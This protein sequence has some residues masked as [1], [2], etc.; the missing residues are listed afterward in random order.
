MILSEQ[1]MLFDDMIKNL[2]AYP[3][4]YQFIYE[5]LIL[6]ERKL[7]SI[8]DP[9]VN[10]AL[11]FCFLKRL[12]DKQLVIHNRIFEVVIS[13]YMITKD[14]REKKREAR[15]RRPQTGRGQRRPL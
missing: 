10:R 7:N 5:L 3:D 9:V 6:G 4:L 13:K 2:E 8:H 11:M 1:N 15:Y 12:D 14:S